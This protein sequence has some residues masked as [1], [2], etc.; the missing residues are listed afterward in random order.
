MAK[1]ETAKEAL[2]ATKDFV[3]AQ[4]VKFGDMFKKII[5]HTVNQLAR[6]AVSLFWDF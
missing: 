1:L 4:K 3:H 5:C 6:F 2:D